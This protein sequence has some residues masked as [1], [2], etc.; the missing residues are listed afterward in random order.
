MFQLN[1]DFRMQVPIY[2]LHAPDDTVPVEE[3][4]SAIQAL[5]EEGRFEKVA[6]YL[7]SCQCS[8][9]SYV[10]WSVKL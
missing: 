3:T 1:V 2:L 5:Y 6:Y 9:I 4:Y 7:T 8:L 10:V